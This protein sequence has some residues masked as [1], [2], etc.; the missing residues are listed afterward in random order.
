MQHAFGF[1]VD[2]VVEFAQHLVLDIA[3]SHAGLADD[4]IVLRGL[5]LRLALHVEVAADDLVPF[6]FG[7]E[8]L[9]PDELSVGHL[10]RG[11]GLGTDDAIDDR[12]VIGD[13]A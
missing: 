10:F 4:A 11:I 13:D 3:T 7:V 12:E 6:E 5:R 9:P 2:D 8:V 1:D